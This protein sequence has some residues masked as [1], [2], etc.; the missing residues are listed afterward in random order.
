MNP[1]AFPE[2]IVNVVLSN[3]DEVVH[4]HLMRHQA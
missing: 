2:V 4:R 1:G 3:D